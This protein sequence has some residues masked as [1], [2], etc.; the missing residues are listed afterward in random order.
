[1]RTSAS[2][3]LAGKAKLV[4]PTSTSAQR[5]TSRETTSRLVEMVQV[6]PA[7]SP[8]RTVASFMENSSASVQLD[9]KAEVVTLT[10]TSAKQTHVGM[11]LFALILQHPTL[12]L[13]FRS[14]VA[15][16]SAAPGGLE[17][18]AILISTNAP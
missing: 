10:L 11:H 3:R 5:R 6:L 9:G 7:L 17:K 2:V 13:Q 15:R 4:K 18:T 12:P 16:A 1:M 8:I 14:T